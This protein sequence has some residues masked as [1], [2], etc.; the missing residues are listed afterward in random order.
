MHPSDSR[1]KLQ[2]LLFISAILIP[3]VVLIT[4]AMRVAR[5]D[6]ELAEKRMEDER[7]DALDQLRRE[8]AARLDTIKLQEQSRLSD[9]SRTEAAA[10]D[11]PVVFAVPLVQN[12]LVLPWEA[13]RQPAASPEFGQYQKEGE[14]REFLGNDFSGAFEAYGQALLAAR[15]P[16]DRCVALLSQA[17]TM[18]KA[19]RKVEAAGI[20][21]GMLHE[22]DS[23]EDGDGMAPA[24]YAAERLISL[25]LDKNP[26]YEYLIR[27]ASSLRWRP[28]IQAYLMRSLL[29]GFSDRDARQAFDTLSAEIHDTETIIALANDLNRLGRL[30]FPFHASPGRSVWLA[31]GDEPWLVTVMSRA[32]FVPPMVLAVSSK[33]ISPPNVKLLATESADSVP[34]GEGFVDLRVEWP[35]GRF[36]AATAIPPSMYVGGIGLILGITMLAGYLLLRDVS[37]EIEVAR[38]RSQFV[39]SVSHELKTPLTAIRMFAET[40]AMGRVPDERTRVEYLETVVNESERLS[41]LVD[42]VLDFSRIERG[43]KIYRMQPVSLAGIVQ[44]AARA[45]QYPL[46]QQGFVLNI[47]IEE[48]IPAVLADADALEQAVLNLLANAMKYSGEAREIDLCLAHSKTEAVI[49][50]IDRGIGIAAEDQPKIFEKFYRIH[51]SY[52]DR[53]AGTG[54]GLTLATHIVKA[55]GGS[56][57]VSSEPGRGSTFSI[58]L[59]LESAEA[60]A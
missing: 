29:R 14:A 60:Q 51:T 20:Y 28:P 54:L 12:R 35:T 47:S 8:L 36:A 18:I 48:H 34:L 57:R 50:V 39:A 52:S 33:K 1:R 23:L 6:A 43:K 42:N 53:V 16:L 15:S 30:D 37:R 19:E 22:C 55:H 56:L 7:R 31:Y 49:K 27:R 58:C 44:A 17:R 40:L 4:L 13:P 11:S 32:S 26:A 38:M 9:E 2:V 25:D 59:P 10:A 45:M 24:L 3:T 46:T 5:Q 21:R 41:R